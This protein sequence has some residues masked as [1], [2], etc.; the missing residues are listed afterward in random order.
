MCV[1]FCVKGKSRKEHIPCRVGPVHCKLL[2][3]AE[4]DLGE[5]SVVC[6]RKKKKGRGSCFVCCD[7][8]EMCYLELWGRERIRTSKPLPFPPECWDY[9]CECQG[10]QLYVV[11]G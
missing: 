9:R 8:Q 11:L 3:M 4:K 5:I 1:Y 2:L 7:G 10:V 6:L